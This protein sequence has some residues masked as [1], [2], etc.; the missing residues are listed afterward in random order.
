MYEIRFNFHESPPP[1]HAAVSWFES[2]GIKKFTFVF[3]RRANATISMK[4]ISVE[5]RR[6]DIKIIRYLIIFPV[7]SGFRSTDRRLNERSPWESRYI[8]VNYPRRGFLFLLSDKYRCFRSD[9]LFSLV[10]YA[11]TNR[12]ARNNL[13]LNFFNRDHLQTAEYETRDE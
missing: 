7:S 3:W 8:Y 12:L 4:S 2:N 10:G 6:D 11:R 1:S 5:N 9:W 13:K